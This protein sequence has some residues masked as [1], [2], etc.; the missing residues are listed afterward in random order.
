MATPNSDNLLLGAGVLY[1]DRFDVNRNKTGERHLGHCSAFTLST[2]V[3]KVQKYNSMSKARALYK[4]VV[5]QTKAI[6]KITLDEFDEHNLALA[7]LGET[8]VYTQTAGNVTDKVTKVY[9]DRWAKL[10]HRLISTVVVKPGS[11]GTTPYIE[12]NDYKVDPKSGRIM[13]L[14]GGAIFTGDATS[15]EVKVSYA[16]AQASIPKVVGATQGKIEGMIRFIGDPGSG[17]AYEG[18]FWK[19]SVTPEGELGFIS[20]DFGSFGLSFECMDD[21]QN[22]PEEPFYRL[23]KI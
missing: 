17:P 21:S 1:F 12:G 9:P 6:G 2:E 3:E 5:R 22:H 20:D 8:G 11:T 19:V 18:E 15:A 10:D 7:L 16:N 14:K 4:E 23:L 13:A